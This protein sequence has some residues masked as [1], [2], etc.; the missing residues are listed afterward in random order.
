[1]VRFVRGICV[2]LELMVY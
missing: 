1:M 2:G